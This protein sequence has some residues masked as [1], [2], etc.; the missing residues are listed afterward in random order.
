MA[1]MKLVFFL[2]TEDTQHITVLTYISNNSVSSIFLGA[3]IHSFYQEECGNISS[4]VQFDSIS[5]NTFSTL[6]ST[7]V[8]VCLYD[9]RSPSID[10]GVG[11]YLW[12]IVA[13]FP[14]VAMATLPLHFCHHLVGYLI[15]WPPVCSVT[16]DEPKCQFLAWINHEKDLLMLIFYIQTSHSNNGAL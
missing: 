11:G 4:I 8:V 6:S 15:P 5:Q 1:K 16:E 9:M 12:P 14:R 7:F 13:V 10:L 2:S 3:I